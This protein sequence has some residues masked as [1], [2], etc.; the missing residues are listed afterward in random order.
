MPQHKNSTVTIII[1]LAIIVLGLNFIVKPY[2]RQKEAEDTAVTILQNWKTGDYV[3]NFDYW[4]E[5]EK[6]PPIYSLNGYSLESED[7][8]KKDG[9][10]QS[11]I[12]VHLDFASDNPLPSGKTWTFHLQK[13][14]EGWR[15]I[16]FYES[17]EEILP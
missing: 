12:S 16:D 14:P 13:M 8:F 2:L 11:L 4:E 15:V 7:F 10:F 3:K 1:C 9:S 5:K 6:A 17:P